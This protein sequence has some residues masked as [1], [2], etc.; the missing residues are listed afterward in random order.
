MHINFPTAQAT[1][2]PMSLGLSRGVFEVKSVPHQLNLVFA[3]FVAQPI[4]KF[5]AHVVADTDTVTDVFWR[6]V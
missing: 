5:G 2:I 3:F 6:D 4:F 1:A